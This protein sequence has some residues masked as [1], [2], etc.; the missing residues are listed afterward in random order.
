MTR[1]KRIPKNKKEG[2]IIPKELK[3]EK[4]EISRKMRSRNVPKKKSGEKTKLT[5]IIPPI[6]TPLKNCFLESP[7]SKNDT[8]KNI[9]KNTGRAKNDT[10]QKTRKIFKSIERRKRMELLSV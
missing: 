3:N 1:K 9:Q 4:C 10:I 6:S 8:N 2:K 7:A 5:V